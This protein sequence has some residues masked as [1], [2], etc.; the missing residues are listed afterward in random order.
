MIDVFERLAP[1]YSRIVRKFAIDVWYDREDVNAFL[2][3]AEFFR[4]RYAHELT[5]FFKKQKYAF[6]PKRIRELSSLWLADQ[7]TT[8]RKIRTIADLKKGRLSEELAEMDELKKAE[9]LSLLDGA[10]QPEGK[11]VPVVSF[12]RNL[13]ARAEQIGE[14]EA[15]SLGREINHDV[16]S[17]MSDVYFWRSQKDRRVRYTHR[18]LADKRFSY[19]SPPTTVDRYGHRH[20]GNPGTDW[21]CRCFEEPGTGRPLLNYIVVEP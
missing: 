7:V 13:A 3:R 8:S 21:G 20:T 17:V 2:Q 18:K 6:N 10:G 19:N 15:F 9:V 1:A 4:R 5:D 11:I 14:D 16:V 12:S